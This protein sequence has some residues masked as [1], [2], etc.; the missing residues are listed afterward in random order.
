MREPVLRQLH[1]DDADAVAA[2]FRDVWGEARPLDAEEIRIWLRNPELQ[3]EWLRVAELGGRV[4]G[5]G[6]IVVRSDEVI[7]DT[8]APG[9]WDAFLDWAED[10]ARDAERGR[11]RVYVPAGHEVEQ[12]LADRGYEL[13][14]SSYT[15]EMDIAPEQRPPEPPSGIALRPYA[16]RDAEPL[17]HAVNDAFQ[18]DPFFQPHSE[19]GFEAF[20]L[21]AR[22]MDPE[23]WLLAWDGDDLAGFALAVPERSGDPAMG[24]VEF[25]GVRAPWRRRGL[26]ECLLRTALH[27]LAERGLPRAGLG[28]DAENVTG[29]LRLYQRVGMQIISQGNNWVGRTGQ[30]D[31]TSG[32]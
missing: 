31:A 17:R 21:H 25:L 20:V 1:E 5:Y 23:L 6:D 28:V 27:R 3:P 12:V 32:R 26:G 24:W 8:A 16:P 18:E 29:A 4:V 13:W 14:R 7:L 19:A 11:V 2:L 22:S 10:H 9:H 30:E 15:M